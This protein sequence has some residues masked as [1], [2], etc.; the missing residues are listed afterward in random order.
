MAM[1]YRMEVYWDQDYWAAEFPELPGLVAGHETWEGLGATIEEAKRSW[2]ESMIEDGKPIPEPQ[3]IEDLEEHFSGKFV[4][5]VPKRI[6]AELAH[7]A[8]KEGVSLNTFVVAA[9]S[10][11]VGEKTAIR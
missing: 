11:A 7:T 3:P 9:L 2:F 4:V 5:R 8:E 1:P 6:H 10:R